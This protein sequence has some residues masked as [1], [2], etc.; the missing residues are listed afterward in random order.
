M[1]DEPREPERKA[2]RKRSFNPLGLVMGVAI[3]TSL[4]V[5]LDNIAVAVGVGA[6]VALVF[7]LVSFTGDKNDSDD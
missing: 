3:G 5:A 7:G 4:A 2:S 1:S 6:G